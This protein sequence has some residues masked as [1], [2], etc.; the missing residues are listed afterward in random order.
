MFTYKTAKFVP[1]WPTV[2]KIRSI[3]VHQSLTERAL[4]LSRSIAFVSHWRLRYNTNGKQAD[5]PINDV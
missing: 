5:A 1:V 2:L 3:F 4:T